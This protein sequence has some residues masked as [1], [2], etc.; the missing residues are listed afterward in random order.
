MTRPGEPI[1][2]IVGQTASGKSG[3]AIELAKLLGAEIINADAMQLYRGMDIGTAKVTEEEKQGIAHHLFDVLDVTE[4]ASVAVYQ[5]RSRAIITDIQ[6]RGK[7]PIL[8]GGSGLYVRAALDH[9]DFP[10]TDPKVRARLYERANS[11]GLRALFA[12]LEE[13]DPHAAATIEPRNDRRIIRA[14]EVIELTDKPFAAS[15]PTQQY[16]ANTVQIAL[17]IDQKELD[18][19][20]ETRVEKMWEAGLVDEVNDLLQ[21]GLAQGPTASR[22]V[23]YAETIR[24]INGEMDAAETIDLIAQSTRR[25]AR[26]QRRWFKRD[27]RIVYVPHTTTAAQV[28]DLISAVTNQR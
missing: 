3:L 14:L 22:A 4:E 1:I 27:E 8:V 7:V 16:V 26:R 6:E 12:E 28:S 23:G 11:E 21:Q 15:L 18:T 5:E 19:R 25:L 2:A 9:M 24:H 10:P 20:I 17:T 13:K